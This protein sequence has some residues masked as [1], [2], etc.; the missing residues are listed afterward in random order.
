M[1]MAQGV[2]SLHSSAKNKNKNKNKTKT[3]N[4]KS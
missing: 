3:N 1:I 4:Y 2:G